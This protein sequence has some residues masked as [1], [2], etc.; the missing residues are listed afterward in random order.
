MGLERVAASYP[1]QLSGGMR[2]RAAIAQNWILNRNIILMDE[3]FSALDVHTRMQ[4]ET[5]LLALW[6]AETRKTVLFVTHDLEE[7]IRLSDEVIV[8]KKGPEHSITARHEI[9][10]PRPRDPM[11]LRGDAAYQNLYSLLWRDLQPDARAA[12]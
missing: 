8:L 11:A 7:A 12:A 1:Y 3:P 6:S 5:E 10:L 9:G 4:M 2:R